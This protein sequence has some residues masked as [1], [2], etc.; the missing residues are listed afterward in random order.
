MEV[1]QGISPQED[2]THSLAEAGHL[3]PANSLYTQSDAFVGPDELTSMAPPYA[4]PSIPYVTAA[5]PRNIVYLPVPTLGETYAERAAPGGVGELMHGARLAQEVFW[6]MI[7]GD[8]ISLAE[9]ELRPFVIDPAGN[10][11]S[12][13]A[14]GLP[15]VPPVFGANEWSSGEM[16]S[17]SH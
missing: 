15:N 12:A 4:G 2:F 14:L 17:I 10:I 1:P 9:P 6:S 5:V 16:V 11:E 3:E 7:L 8:D 13:I